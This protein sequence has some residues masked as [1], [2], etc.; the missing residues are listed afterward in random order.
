MN[1]KEPLVEELRGLLIGEGLTEGVNLL[2]SESD[3]VVLAQLMAVNLGRLGLLLAVL[4][5]PG[6]LAD[7]DSLSSRV[8]SG[9]NDG[10]RGRWRYELVSSRYPVNEEIVFLGKIRFPAA[11]LPEVIARLRRDRVTPAG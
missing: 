8:A 7:P 1:N 5:D 9:S 11:D 10:D 2:L 4:S 3:G 6:E